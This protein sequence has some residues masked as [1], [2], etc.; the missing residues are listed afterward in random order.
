MLVLIDKKLNTY[1]EPNLLQTS[2]ALL[3]LFSI[4]LFVF[5]V[6]I[7]FYLQ[8]R[9]H[10]GRS[11]K[12]LTDYQFY[13]IL[14]FSFVVVFAVQIC[15]CSNIY[16]KT[17]WDAGYIVNA[18][19]EIAIGHADG[20]PVD[21]F[22][23]NPNNMFLIYTLVLLFKMG[24]ALNNGDPYFVVLIVVSL[25]VCISV[26]LSTLC[27]YRITGDRSVTI[28]G[29]ILGT[30]LIA[31]SPWI[32]IPYS[33]AIGMI[34]PVSAI[35]CYLYVANS[36]IK[37]FFITLL[38]TLGYYFKPTVAII[39]IALVILKSCLGIVKLL[40]KEASVKRFACLCLSGIIAISC[41]MG[42]NKL[43]Q[44]VNKTELDKTREMTMTHYLM[45]GLNTVHEGVF[46]KSDVEYSQSFPDVLSRQS[47]NIEAIKFRLQE[48]GI[49]GF[50]KLITKKNLA[51][52]NDGTFAWAREGNFYM[53]IKEN[54]SQSSKF[55][56]S[57]Y[58][59]DESGTHFQLFA[60]TEQVIWMMLLICICF[61]VFPRKKYQDAEGLIALTLLGV[62]LFLLLFE[63][64][65]RYLYIFSPLYMILGCTGL[66][67]ASK[68]IG[69]ISYTMNL[70]NIHAKLL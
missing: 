25:L 63:C 34:F 13:L 30:F 21:Y 16:M 64:R 44:F 61:C 15:I 8:K 27:I 31:F 14:A 46:S 65:S 57:F 43:I 69:K 67:K 22:S 35:F 58:Y 49:G 18:A 23:S 55:F 62:S 68:L 17:G 33:D 20:V 59:T 38:C 47:A 24:A 2:N 70:R 12:K 28:V 7:V 36:Y 5:L 53:Q 52:Y 32:V 9:Q 19:E 41:V 4:L 39:L 54:D 37:Y 60:S 6:V 1:Y 56:R 40:K 42:I 50:L 11:G 48:M 3:I 26:F 66:Y 29:M 51:T 10:I 45:M